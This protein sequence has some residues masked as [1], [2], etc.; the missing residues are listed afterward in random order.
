MAQSLRAVPAPV[1]QPV[2]ADH[3][4]VQLVSRKRKSKYKRIG[5]DHSHLRIIRHRRRLISGFATKAKTGINLFTVKYKKSG[6]AYYLTTR[7]VPST[8]KANFYLD[9]GHSE[10][11]FSLIRKRFEKRHGLKL[12]QLVWAVTEREPCGCGPGMA[13]CRHTLANL[14]IPEAKVLYASP[15]PDGEDYRSSP[16]QT[17]TELNEIASSERET[18]AEE[19]TDEITNLKSSGY[20]SDPDSED[21]DDIEAVEY[22]SD[23]DE[24]TAPRAKRGKSRLDS[25]VYGE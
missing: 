3:N 18:Y 23:Y 1:I 16:S 4:V 13:N 11:R 2:A 17:K 15:Y 5:Y 10:E 20:V 12:A 24:Y 7:S 19:L 21:E 9:A 25:S 14:G 22:E 6:K 8:N